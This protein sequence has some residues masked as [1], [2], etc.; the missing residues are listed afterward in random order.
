ML[1][2]RFFFYI[3]HKNECLLCTIFGY[4]SLHINLVK[5]SYVDCYFYILSKILDTL[6]YLESSAVAISLLYQKFHGYKTER[7]QPT[8][9]FFLQPT[10][11][12]KVTQTVRLHGFSHKL[13]YFK[14]DRSNYNFWFSKRS[15]SSI[16]LAVRFS[17]CKYLILVNEC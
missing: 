14:F 11:S 1:E 15:I 3:S 16:V 13:T 5:A 2:I 4:A 6:F 17:L 8:P 12:L 9:H 7:I 10:S